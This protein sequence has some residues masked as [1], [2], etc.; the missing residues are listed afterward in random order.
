MRFLTFDFRLSEIGNYNCVCWG[1][2][3]SVAALFL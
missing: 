2:S 1:G 3:E